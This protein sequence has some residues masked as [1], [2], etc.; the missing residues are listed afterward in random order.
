MGGASCAPTLQ[1]C[2]VCERPGLPPQLFARGV[3]PV[4]KEHRHNSYLAAK[5]LLGSWGV[6]VGGGVT[7]VTG[8]VEDLLE[9]G[10]APFHCEA[11]GG[12]QVPR[13]PL[14]G[15]LLASPSWEP[16]RPPGFPREMFLVV[17]S[18]IMS[19][20]VGCLGVGVCCCVC[21]VG[22]GC[23]IYQTI[24]VQGHLLWPR[25][26]LWIRQW[27]IGVQPALLGISS[28]ILPRYKRSFFQGC[29]GLF[30]FS[31]FFFLMQGV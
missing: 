19:C 16:V 7:G 12:S 18:F 4:C 31:F 2:L 23:G 30:N 15:V 9:D 11:G 24:P 8:E 28:Q 25:E 29:C 5:F 1:H 21:V 22:R 27:P 14:G 17:L 26:L 6:G 20:S 3:H 10:T 13:G